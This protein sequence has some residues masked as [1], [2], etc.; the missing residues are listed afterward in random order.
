MCLVF[1]CHFVTA[2]QCIA[3]WFLRGIHSHQISFLHWT[4]WSVAALCDNHILHVG[5]SLGLRS[6]DLAH[7]G[8][9]GFEG[10]QRRLTEG[11]R[12][13]DY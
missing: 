4:W 5:M 6:H 12:W 11:K 10:T 2:L 9:E 3:G 13:K 1:V 8:T 7:P